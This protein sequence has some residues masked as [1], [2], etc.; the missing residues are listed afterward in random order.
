MCRFQ[1]E[2][3]QFVINFLKWKVAEKLRKHRID[4]ME[5]CVENEFSLE[6]QHET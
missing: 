3:L 5:T 1:M 6:T 4:V 2:T